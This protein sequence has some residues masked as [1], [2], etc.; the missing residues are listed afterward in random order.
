MGGTRRSFVRRAVAFGTIPAFGGVA[1]CAGTDLDPDGAGTSDG[2]DGEPDGGA[3]LE[4]H[5]AME[6][7][8]GSTALVGQLGPTEV[9]PDEPGGGRLVTI[10]AVDPGEVRFSW[11]QTVEREITPTATPDVGVGGE[12]PS[13]EVEIVEETGT[14]TATGIDDAHA[15][16]LPMYWR[17]GEVQTESS[18]MWLS[19]AAFRELRDTR[20][21]RW[22]KDVLSRISRLSEEAVARIHRGI[23]EVD[24]VYLNAEADFGA[25]EITVDQEQTSLQVIEAHDTFGNAYQILDNEANP[26]V[27]KFTYDAVST[28][29]AGIDAGLW[30]LIKTVF[31]GYQVVSIDTP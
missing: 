22:S 13:P 5:P 10:E 4:L 16:F 30:A 7:G 1:G 20:Q 12:T 26:L 25:I 24:E 8:I 15:P 9:D 14:I 11:R 19:R 31:S 27:V 21:T 3:G 2:D 18:A 28:G 29:F 17:P 6:I 23:E